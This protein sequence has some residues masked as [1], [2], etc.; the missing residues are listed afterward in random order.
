MLAALEKSDESMYIAFMQ[1]PN[2]IE[3]IC[4]YLVMMWEENNTDNTI[5]YV[6][7]TDMFSYPSLAVC[8]L[9]DGTLFSFEITDFELLEA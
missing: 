9:L 2:S 8:S 6:Q 5:E 4:D 7:V 3:H 1:N